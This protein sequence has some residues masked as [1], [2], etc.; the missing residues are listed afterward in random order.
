MKVVKRWNGIDVVINNAGVATGDRIDAGD[1][2]WWNWIIDINLKGRGA[3]LP[4]LYPTDETARQR[5]VYQRGLTW[6]AY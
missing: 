6:P 2:E 3:G 4:H 5:R 1:W